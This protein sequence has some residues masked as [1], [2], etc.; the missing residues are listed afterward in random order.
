VLLLLVLLLLVLLLLVLLLLVLLLLALLLLALLL[1][2]L[3]LPLLLL[4][5]ASVVGRVRR[6]DPEDH[7]RSELSRAGPQRRANISTHSGAAP[8]STLR[9]FLVWVSM[10]P[11]QVPQHG[12]DSKRTTEG[13]SLK[14]SETPYLKAH[15]LKPTTPAS[16]PRKFKP[17]RRVHAAVAP[18]PKQKCAS[19]A[20]ASTHPRSD[21]DL[22]SL[23]TNRLAG[24]LHGCLTLPP[25]ENF[26]PTES[27][28]PT[29]R[30]R[31][32]NPVNA[33]STLHLAVRP[34]APL[35]AEISTP[36]D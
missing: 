27:P 22:R 14:T 2:A 19:H 21:S 11:P 3:P 17:P 25:H 26:A 4:L 12:R 5:L 31:I 15:P 36:P 16:R 23:K 1:L 10:S 34:T 28:Q 29:R 24:I 8:G 9:P 7:Q 13:S 18:P 33:V 20:D 6:E 35:A 30:P 32:L